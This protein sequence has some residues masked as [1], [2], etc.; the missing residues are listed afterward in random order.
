MKS[1]GMYFGVSFRMRSA[2]SGWLGVTAYRFSISWARIIPLGGRKDAI[3]TRGVQ[4][5]SEFI[6]KLL[7]AGITPFVTLFHWDMPLALYERYGGMLNTEEFT[8][9]FKRYSEVCFDFFGDR[10]KHWIT[11]NEPVVVAQLV[12]FFTSQVTAMSKN[13][14]DML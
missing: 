4:W 6:D 1:Y 2:N 10:V 5:Y 7:E 3:E 8:Q 9:D 11:F 13:N 14:S 12:S